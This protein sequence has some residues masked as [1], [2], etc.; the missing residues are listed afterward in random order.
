MQ[1][2]WIYTLV[3]ITE[4]KQYRNEQG[5]ELEKKQQQNFLSL[6]QTISLRANPS[7]ESSPKYFY[8]DEKT[9]MFGNM[10]QGPQKIWKF[11]F[12]IE[13]EYA[14]KDQDG[15]QSGLL[16][17]DLNLVPIIIELT[18]TANIHL[19]VFDTVSDDFKNTVIEVE[20]DK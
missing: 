14:F 20:V 6:L 8:S 16:T 15:N 18:E 19:P 7:Y 2:F 12:C 13:Y 11:N 3:D 9:N 1:N 17:K 10:Y 5:K 4:T